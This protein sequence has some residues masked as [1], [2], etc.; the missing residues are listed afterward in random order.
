MRFALAVVL[1]TVLLGVT[2]TER[3]AL[4]GTYR[5]G[6]ST[7]YDPPVDE[8]QNTHLYVELT[9]SGARDLYE[10]MAVPP[11]ADEC[12]GPNASVKVIGQMQCN[13]YK[14]DNRYRCWFGV[15]VRTQS[16]TRG[17]IC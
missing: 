3:R 4:Y 10:A 8:P 5:L 1:L 2:A 16:I 11:K 13:R 17:V 15:D 14:S 9:G 7:L 6:G 12:T